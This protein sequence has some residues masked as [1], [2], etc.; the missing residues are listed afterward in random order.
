MKLRVNRKIVPSGFRGITLY[1][2]IFAKDEEALKDDIFLNHEK[3]HLAQQKELLVIGFYLIYAIEFAYQYIIYRDSFKAY[4]NI[5]FEREA[6]A[7]EKNPEYLS[8][9]ERFSQWK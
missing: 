3:I 7:N 5:S 1:P 4:W 8:T 6:Y 9:R 2:F